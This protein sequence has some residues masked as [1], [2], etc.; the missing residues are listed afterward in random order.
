MQRGINWYYRIRVYD[1]IDEMSHNQCR[2]NRVQLY[3]NKQPYSPGCKGATIF[4]V[5]NFARQIASMVHFRFLFR[6]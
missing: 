5:N 3:N 4:G 1:V 2:Y 6:S